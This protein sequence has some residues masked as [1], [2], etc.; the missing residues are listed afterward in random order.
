MR[1]AWRG[2][3]SAASAAAAL[4]ELP[5]VTPSSATAD[6][7]SGNE[8]FGFPVAVAVAIAPCSA[9]TPES[10]LSAERGVDYVLRKHRIGFNE[11]LKEM[12]ILIMKVITRYCWNNN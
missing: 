12:L 11:I 4:K 10:T 9:M 8:E 6:S 5:F 3:L 2:S 1:R 7:S